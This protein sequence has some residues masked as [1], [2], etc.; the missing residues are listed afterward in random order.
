MCSCWKEGLGRSG[1]AQYWCA[2]CGEE[3]PPLSLVAYLED[4]MDSAHALILETVPTPTPGG[5]IF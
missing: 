2:T 1:P 4:D 3:V 5:K